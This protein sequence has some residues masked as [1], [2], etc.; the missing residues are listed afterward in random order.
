M[1]GAAKIFPLANLG[2]WPNQG[3]G[4]V[5]WPAPSPPATLS[6]QNNSS[7]VVGNVMEQ[8]PFPA[9]LLLS[10]FPTN[11]AFYISGVESHWGRS[12]RGGWWSDWMACKN[13]PKANAYLFLSNKCALVPL[14]RE[15]RQINADVRLIRGGEQLPSLTL[16][17]LS[18]Q[19]ST[20]VE[21]AW[22]QKSYFAL[23]YF[24]PIF[25]QNSFP[26]G[27]C[28]VNILWKNV[29]CLI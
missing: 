16:L 19:N 25:K 14:C 12:Y 11:I 24:K 13:F 7:R 8:S 3:G 10:L 18:L 20:K 21:N 15:R 9:S 4:F 28:L 5:V 27:W 29:H 23:K 22:A 17:A 26:H 2:H 1:R 6:R